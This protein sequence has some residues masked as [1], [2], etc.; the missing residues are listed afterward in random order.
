MMTKGRQCNS[1]TVDSRNRDIDLNI[2][3]RSAAVVGLAFDYMHITIV[4]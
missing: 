4:L 1:Q 3:I 2:N